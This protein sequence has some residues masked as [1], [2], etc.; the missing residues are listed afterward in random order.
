MPLTH[1]IEF[2]QQ[3]INALHQRPGQSR[4]W[5]ASVEAVATLRTTIEELQTCEEELHQQQ[6][7]LAAAQHAVEVERQ[8]YQELF[9]FAPDAYL[10]TD[11]MG[12]IQQANRAAATLLAE[13]QYHLAGKPIST[14]IAQEE[15]LSFRA[16][17]AGLA[18]IQ[19]RQDW[20]VRLQLHSGASFPASITVATVRDAGD[21]GQNLR[22]LIRDI[23]TRKWAE[24]ELRKASQELKHQV[25]ERTTQFVTA[26]ESL[27][28]EIAI[29]KQAEAQLLESERLALLG[30]IAKKVAHEVGN[31]L[32]NMATTVQ[33]Q[34][35]YLNTSHVH[36]DSLL[37][38]TVKDLLEE[39]Q[40]LGVI[41]HGWR[42]IAQYSHFH[43]QP[44]DVSALAAE[45]LATQDLQQKFSGITVVQDCP[46]GLPSV[47]ADRE[48]LKQA[49][50]NVYLNA[51][52]AMPQGGTLTLRVFHAKEHVIVEVG[53]TG[54]GIPAGR[55]IFDLFTSTQ[56][57]SLGVGLVIAQQLIVAHGGTLTYTS[58]LGKGTVFRLA[59][60]QQE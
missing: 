17:L 30:L 56:P 37:N 22:W 12:V 57:G 47:R 32:N 11:H 41:V 52:T 14:F 26:N 7:A 25:A 34:Q 58:E 21:N 1:H 8:R 27:R 10:I 59:L 43:I 53:D 40:R 49:L 13:P 46:L 2:L 45:V 20:E 35:R 54:T 48:R 55:D 50:L 36:Q 28:S 6:E 19:Q 60:P 39:I 42:S 23:S 44:T 24:E 38:S 3:Q 15:R 18:A 31:A 29:R 16:Q 9:D 4:G 33:L 5:R 51:V